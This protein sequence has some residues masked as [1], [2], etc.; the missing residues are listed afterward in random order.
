MSIKPA[1][2]LIEVLLSV[3]LFALIVSGLTGAI[4]YVDQTAVLAGQ[5]S[6]AVFLAEEG[7]EAVRNIKAAGFNNLQDGNYGLTVQNGVWAFSGSPDTTG[8]FTRKITI[9]TINSAVK[10]VTATVTWRQNLQRNGSI[11]IVTRLGDYAN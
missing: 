9:T 11:S 8:M 1:F 2:S 5:Q 6:R 3:A 10:E 7:I 4:I